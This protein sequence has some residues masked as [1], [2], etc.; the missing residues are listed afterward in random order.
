[1]G[2]ATDGSECSGESSS[3]PDA[4]GEW[5]VMRGVTGLW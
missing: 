4:V 5:S 1:L 2:R 3:A